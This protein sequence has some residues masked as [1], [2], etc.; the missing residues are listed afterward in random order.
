MSKP[1]EV[2]KASAPSN[3]ALIKYMGKSQSE[4]NRPANASLSYTLDHLLTEVEISR[5]EDL[6]QDVWAPLDLPDFYELRLSA[7]GEKKFIDFFRFLKATF[8]VDGFYEIRSANNFPSDCGIASSASSFAALTLA[9]YQLALDV[10]AQKETVES[11]GL[12]DLSKISRKGSG[13]ACRSLFRPWALWESEGARSLELP[14]G[15]LHHLV[16]LASDQVKSVSSREAHQ[17]I[18][19]SLLFNGRIE[20]AELRLKSLLS[21]LNSQDWKSSFEFCWSE[22]WD[23]HALFETSSPAFGYMNSESLKVLSKIRSSWQSEG[24]GPLVTMDAG[25]NV[26][27][28]YRMDQKSLAVK[29]WNEFA[30]EGIKILA[31]PSLDRDS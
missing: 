11:L 20:R 30:L 7:E 23:M 12:E 10:S 14:Y 2:W 18:P 26:H 6:D 3:I 28:L 27:L 31:S 16:V 9:A 29:H 22:F 15:H 21:S 17:R 25:P 8:S 19:S 24:D 13:S 1:V 5:R 4:N